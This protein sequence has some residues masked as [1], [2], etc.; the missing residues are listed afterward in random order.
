MPSNH[1]I[2][3]HPLLLLPSILP[4][5][6]VFFSESVLRIR[7][8]KYWGFSFSI[9]PPNEY[10]GLISFRIDW[11][12][13]LAVRGTLRS[14]LQ[15]HLWDLG[16]LFNLCASVFLSVKGGIIKW[17]LPPGVVGRINCV[18]C[19]IAHLGWYL[20]LRKQY[21]FLKICLYIENPKDSTRKLL[22]LINE[23]SKVAG[24]S[25]HRNPFHS[26]TLIMRK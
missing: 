9:S 4:R 25:T 17:H 3:C 2:L 22:E 26:Y 18:T 24:K 12:G 20:S 23:Y 7:W 14:L 8:P 10:S 13:L 21:L 11:F 5:I 19:K 1:L 15:H 16:K 6:K